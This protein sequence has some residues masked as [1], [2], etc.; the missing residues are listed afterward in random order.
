MSAAQPQ[1]VFLAGLSGSG[2]TTA[3]AALEDLSF[4]CVDNLPAQLV[5]QFL[6]L[7]KQGDPPITKVALAVDTRE[8]QFLTEVPAAVKRLRQTGIDV[9]VIYLDC[10]QEVLEKRYQETRRVHPHAP[11]GT[12]AAGIER[13]RKLLAELA[14]LADHVVDTSSLNVH[15]LK[16]DVMRRLAGG[17]RSTVVNLV[18]FGFRYPSP[19]AAELLFDVRFLPNPYFEEALRPLSGRDPA[20]AAHVLESE[21]GA[22]LMRHLGSLLTFL[23]PL[24]DQEGKAYLTIGVGC[25]GGRHRSV[26]IT[27]AVAELLRG[28][29]RE[30]N[31]EHRDV[32]RAQ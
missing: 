27:E 31:V 1:V 14:G 3:M 13:E 17:T 29:Q 26:A 2:K 18:S 5:E 12:V 28:T 15:E 4:Y 8:A 22:E 25:T 20:V 6:H 11:A 21:R 10:A 9:V 19:Q 23:L 24:Y 30:V 7:C 32:E 16:A